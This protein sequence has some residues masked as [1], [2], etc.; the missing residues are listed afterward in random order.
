MEA[1]I[2]SVGDE[3]QRGDIVNTNAAYLAKQLNN[4]GISVHA[5]LTVGDDSP[6]I[7]NSVQEAAHRVQLIFVC[8]G[9]GPTADDVTLAAVAASMEEPV[10][11]DEST[12]QHL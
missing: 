5:Q 3:L 7:I 4:L 1:E 8:G 10:K 6:A 11:T 12:W 2:I 9:L